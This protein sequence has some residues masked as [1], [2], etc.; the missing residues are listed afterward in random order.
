[1]RL[2]NHHSNIRSRATG[3]GVYH[4]YYK[5]HFHWFN[6]FSG[7]PFLNHLAGSFP[8]AESTKLVQSLFITMPAEMWTDS[9]RAWPS[10]QWVGNAVVTYYL[11]LVLNDIGIT[12]ATNQALINGGLQIF[13]LLASVFCGALFVDRLGRRTLFLW[14][15]AGMG[16]SYIVSLT[17]N[18]F[19]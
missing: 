7:P 8:R 19:L 14:S 6:S 3:A 4:L 1:M 13:N 17:S 5:A 9:C 2:G 12:N 15:A 18:L 10:V 16:S 11:V